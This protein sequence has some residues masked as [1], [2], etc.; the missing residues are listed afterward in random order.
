MYK[1]ECLEL[2]NKAAY[3]IRIIYAQYFP[4]NYQNNADIKNEK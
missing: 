4:S 3:Q 1:K 2:C